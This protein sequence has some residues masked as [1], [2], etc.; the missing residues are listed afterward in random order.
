MSAH[1][2]TTCPQALVM[3]AWRPLMASKAAGR[4]VKLGRASFSLGPPADPSSIF[5]Y[6]NEAVVEV[7]SEKAGGEADV[8]LEGLLQVLPDDGLQA[9]ACR[10]VEV[11]GEAIHR[12]RVV[13][14]FG[15]RREEGSARRDQQEEK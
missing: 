14:G 5:G 11:E 3:R 4:R 9:G 13:I 15:G 10:L 7:E 8:V 2:T 12:R 6:L 1:E